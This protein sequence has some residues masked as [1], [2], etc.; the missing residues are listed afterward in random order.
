MQPGTKLMLTCAAVLVVI[1]AGALL[2][3]GKWKDKSGAPIKSPTEASLPK[4]GEGLPKFKLTTRYKGRLADSWSADL[5]DSDERTSYWG[6]YALNQIGEEGLPYMLAGMKSPVEHVRN[7][8]LQFLPYNEAKKHPKQF[9]PAVSRLLTDE[10]AGVRLQ[11]AIA[12]LHCRF[13]EL[14][15]EL[16]AAH[17]REPSPQ[18]RSDMARYIKMLEEQP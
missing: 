15:P 8:S 16:R 3:N 14:L 2:L 7:Y 11:A 12:L 10:S 13:V 18:V 1:G 17:D 5:F 4:V 9:S 6:A